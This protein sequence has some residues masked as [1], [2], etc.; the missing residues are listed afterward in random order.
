M[1]KL[2]SMFNSLK[3]DHLTSYQ[4]QL[5]SAKKTKCSDGTTCISFADEKTAMTFSKTLQQLGIVGA[6][7]NQKFVAK[8]LR[9]RN[10][11]GVILTNENFKKIN[12]LI[13]ARFADQLTTE[14]KDFKTSVN[15]HYRNSPHVLKNLQQA[16]TLYAQNGDLSESFEQSECHAFGGGAQPSNV[17]DTFKIAVDQENHGGVIQLIQAITE[18]NIEEQFQLK[19]LLEEI[20]NWIDTNQL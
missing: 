15:Q 4:D 16:L 10:D 19:S 17:E 8:H 13:A 1:N 9:E 18:S 14:I 5:I 3:I 7:G 2:F 11:F 6:S 12:Q 20:S